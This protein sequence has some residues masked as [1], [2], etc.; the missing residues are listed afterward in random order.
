MHSRNDYTLQYYKIK[1]SNYNIKTERIK[2]LNSVE[3]KNYSNSYFFCNFT[4]LAMNDISMK[5]KLLSIKVVIENVTL[6]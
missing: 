1:S 5:W 2:N 6:W 4:S 3:G